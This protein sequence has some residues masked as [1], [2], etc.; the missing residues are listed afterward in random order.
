M[1]SRVT[2]EAVTFIVAL[3]DA[4]WSAV[5]GTDHK[6]LS[7]ATVRLIAA[8]QHIPFWILF[9]IFVTHYDSVLAVRDLFGGALVI[10]MANC[11]FFLHCDKRG[12]FSPALARATQ[13]VAAMLIPI[14]FVNMV[15]C[16][17]AHL[18]TE[19]CNRDHAQKIV[20]G[21]D[22]GDGTIQ[23][24]S[25][26]HGYTECLWDDRR[27]N[28]GVAGGCFILIMMFIASNCMI[29]FKASKVHRK[30]GGLPTKV[31]A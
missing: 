18:S 30:M 17:H 5:S 4:V 25:L 9:F 21:R 24:L 23:S 27:Y 31:S 29:V 3:G 28:Q 15:V 16:M 11:I 10:S 8:L 13:G 20:C 1:S 12:D 19:H 22:A 14:Q 26:Q 2:E 7:P 6:F